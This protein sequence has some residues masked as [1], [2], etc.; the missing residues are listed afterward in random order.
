MAH[1]SQMLV[2]FIHVVAI[3]EGSA[4]WDPLVTQFK[5]YGGCM[6]FMIWQAQL[7]GL[8]MGAFI[9]VFL[10]MWV[11]HHWSIFT[12]AM[13]VSLYHTSAVRTHA[14]ELLLHEAFSS[15]KW[16]MFYLWGV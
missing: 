13:F 11:S 6:L 8:L 9:M 4:H 7:I 2:K 14:P 10:Q 16:L 1:I 12:P 5:Q 15:S 3:S